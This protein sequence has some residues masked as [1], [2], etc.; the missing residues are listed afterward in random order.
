MKS[1]SGVFMRFDGG[2]TS[3][4][5]CGQSKKQ[6]GVSNT[7]PESYIFAADHA[8]LTEGLLAL[9]LREAVLWCKVDF[10]LHEDNEASIP[11]MKSG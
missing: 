5:L 4:T 2:N 9:D 3:F 7:T 11:V 10:R 8:S 6:T 1:K